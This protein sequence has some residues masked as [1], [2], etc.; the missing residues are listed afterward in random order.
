MKKTISKDQ[1]A[2]S[3]SGRA[4]PRKSAADLLREALAAKQ[5]AA[6]AQAPRPRPSPG[7]G[8]TAKDA[9]RR[10]GKSRKVH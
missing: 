2:T 6:P 5:A 3:D 8:R 7:G 4:T 10:S 1:P 9:E